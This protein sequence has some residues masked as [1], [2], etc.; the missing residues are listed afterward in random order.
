MRQERRG[1][2]AKEGAGRCRV[3][4]VSGRSARETS[5]EEIQFAFEGS[6]PGCRV[7]TRTAGGSSWH[8]FG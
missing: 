2:K 4:R 3:L 1:F 7:S 8:N 5:F 6:L